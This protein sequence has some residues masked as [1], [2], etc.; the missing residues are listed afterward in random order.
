MIS[1][2]TMVVCPFIALYGKGMS[3]AILQHMGERLD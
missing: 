1:Y 3:D 2:I